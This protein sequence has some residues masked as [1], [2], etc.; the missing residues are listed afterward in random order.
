MQRLKEAYGA[1]LEVC[2]TILNRWLRCV[3]GL[4]TFNKDTEFEGTSGFE[5]DKNERSAFLKRLPIRQ[6]FGAMH[7][8]QA[9]YMDVAD[10]LQEPGFTL[11]S[12]SYDLAYVFLQMTAWIDDDVSQD[13]LS[14]LLIEFNTGLISWFTSCATS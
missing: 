9:I 14:E 12:F 5:G 8:V 2:Q 10:W 13:D 7:P 11:E 4:I 3:R 6:R 1:K